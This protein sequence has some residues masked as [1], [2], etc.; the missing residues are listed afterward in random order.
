M[1]NYKGLKYLEKVLRL[2]IIGNL[3][4]LR[5]QLESEIPQ[6]TAAD[7][8][9]L[10]TWNIREFGDNRTVESLYYITEIISR[11][12]IV[13]VHEVS[14]NMAGIKKLLDNNWGLFLTDSTDGS[15]CLAYLYDKSKIRFE[16]LAGNLVLASDNLVLKEMQFAR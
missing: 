9:L 6:K 2:R 14:S 15:E 8:L 12:N 5:W 7:T 11:F 1:A 13:A 3:L 16:D 4:T 10:A